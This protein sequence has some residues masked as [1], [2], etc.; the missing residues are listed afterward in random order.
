MSELSQEL[1]LS[2]EQK[3]QLARILDESRQQ[4]EELN[5]TLRPRFR[6]IRDDTRNQIRDLMSGGQV[7]AFNAVVEKWDA[8]RRKR[9]EVRRDTVG[10]RGPRGTD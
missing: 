1:D 3:D 6:E 5:R 9:S 7:D 2:A 10:A 8:R 4:M